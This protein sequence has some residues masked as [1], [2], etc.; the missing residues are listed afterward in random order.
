MDLELDFIR[1]FLIDLDWIHNPNKSDWA[2]PCPALQKCI[3]KT[4]KYEKNEKIW[5][6][7]STI[8]TPNIIIN[9]KKIFCYIKK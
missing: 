4:P 1:G 6:Q 5:T 8:S 2:T 9:N 7:K 3:Q